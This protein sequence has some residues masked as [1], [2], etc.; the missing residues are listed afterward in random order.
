[1]K[2]E[3]YV[4]MTEHTINYGPYDVKVLPAGTFVKPIQPQYLPKHIKDCRTF[5]LML[6]TDYIYCYT[7]YG[8]IPIPSNIIRCVNG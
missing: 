4:L 2:I 1:M 8:I 5:S 3:E 6:K 7:Y